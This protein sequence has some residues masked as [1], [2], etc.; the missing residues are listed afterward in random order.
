VLYYKPSYPNHSACIIDVTYAHADDVQHQ[1]IVENRIGGCY[2][3][4]RNRQLLWRTKVLRKTILSVSVVALLA[5][6]AEAAVLQLQGIA[7]VDNGGGFVKATNNM[8][9]NPG[10]R[11]RVN[12][13]FAYVVYDNGYQSKVGGGQM[14]VVVSDAPGPFSAGAPETPAGYWG[15]A[16][17]VAT[18]IGAGAAIAATGTG[19]GTVAEVVTGIGPAPAAPR[20]VS[21]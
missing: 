14:A 9:L 20:S 19:I 3:K 16:F 7:S 4:D 11:V 8:Q 13:G 1:R 12:S 15:A 10:D 6:Q 2:W 18:G 21:P 17:V 5:T